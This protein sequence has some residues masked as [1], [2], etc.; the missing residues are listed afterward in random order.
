MRADRPALEAGR[1]PQVA[2]P[3]SPVR[4]GVGRC[5]GVRSC[6]SPGPHGVPL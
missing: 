4:T 3:S 5:A 2:A 1:A 6:T